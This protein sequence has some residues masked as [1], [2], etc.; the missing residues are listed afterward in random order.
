MR[1]QRRRIGVAPRRIVGLFDRFVLV[2]RGEHEL[3]MSGRLKRSRKREAGK[4]SAAW[5]QPRLTCQ[6]IRSSPPGEAM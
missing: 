2:E 1:D 5:F 6:P 4:K 3:T